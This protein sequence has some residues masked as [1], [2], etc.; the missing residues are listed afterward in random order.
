MIYN[1]NTYDFIF[2]KV[3]V[4]MINPIS[5]MSYNYIPTT[6]TLPQNQQLIKNPEE[7]TE[8]LVGKQSSPAE[9]ET[10]ASR[11]YQDGS[12]EMVSFKSAAHISPESAASKVRSPVRTL[13][14]L[15]SRYM[16][17]IRDFASI[18]RMSFCSTEYSSSSVT[19]SAAEDA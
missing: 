7:S 4:T 18:G 5:N 12:N 1:N 6:N 9:C 15:V 16:P 3:G 2:R 13:K 17:A 14:F 19:R 8:K 11:K 10:C